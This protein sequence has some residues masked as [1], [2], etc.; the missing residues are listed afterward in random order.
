MVNGSMK[1]FE[2]LDEM[3]I[4]EEGLNSPSGC[5]GEERKSVQ[6]STAQH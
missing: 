4:T 6:S 1:M 3:S 5:N 2:F